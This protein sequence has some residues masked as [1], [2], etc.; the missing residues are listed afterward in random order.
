[1]KEFVRWSE[2]LLQTITLKVWKKEWG[3]GFKRR[4]DQLQLVYMVTLLLLNWYC[5]SV[6]WRS[7]GPH[8]YTKQTQLPCFCWTRYVCYVYIHKGGM[9]VNGD[10]VQVSNLLHLL[11]TM[12]PYVARPT[13]NERESKSAATE[14]GQLNCSHWS[15]YRHSCDVC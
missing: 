8:V 9:I 1:M 12:G 5:Q 14:W 4:E 13:D 11:N 15:M 10:K 6:L 2:R 3:N 7:C